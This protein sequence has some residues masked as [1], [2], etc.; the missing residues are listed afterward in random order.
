MTAVVII[1]FGLL[2]LSAYL[3]AIVEV[4]SNAVWVRF[5]E[6]LKEKQSVSLEHLQEEQSV[7]DL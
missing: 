7:E 1:A 4:F 6:A 2:A 3:T 5:F